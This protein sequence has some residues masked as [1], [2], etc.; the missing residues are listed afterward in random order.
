MLQFRLM[1][2]I[3][4]KTCC[5]FAVLCEGKDL[6]SLIVSLLGAML[7]WMDCIFLTFWI[8]FCLVDLLL[9][10]MLTRVHGFSF[11]FES[12][13][14]YY[15]NGMEQ[16]VSVFYLPVWLASCCDADVDVCFFFT[17]WIMRWMLWG[18]NGAG[19]TC[20]DSFA[21]L[22]CFLLRCWRG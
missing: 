15:G 21:W 4:M 7:I 20:K 2:W 3:I 11:L 14:K 13:C 9:P 8:M 12:C 17:V 1:S 18:W 5:V 10:A 16:E 6:I 19:S 22:I